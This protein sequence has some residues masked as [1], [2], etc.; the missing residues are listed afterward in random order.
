MADDEQ[1]AVPPGD[2]REDN[3]RIARRS[4][5][6][7]RQITRSRPDRPPQDPAGQRP[8]SRALLVAGEI[9]YHVR[10]LEM[11][12]TPAAVARQSERPGPDCYQLRTMSSR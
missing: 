9:Q 7:Y 1:V 2:A 10:M 8:R 5:D 11:P 3:T 4:L 12:V 6:D